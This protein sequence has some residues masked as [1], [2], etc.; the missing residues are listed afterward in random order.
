MDIRCLLCVLLCSRYLEGYERILG[1]TWTIRG[2]DQM[3]DPG[4][5]MGTGKRVR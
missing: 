5:T 3:W 4:G 2:R 1:H